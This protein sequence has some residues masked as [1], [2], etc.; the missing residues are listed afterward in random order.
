MLGCL[1]LVISGSHAGSGP[2]CGERE[3]QEIQSRVSGC[4]AS[5]TFQFEDARDAA[6][7][8][9]DVREDIRMANMDLELWE[10]FDSFDR[11]DAMENFIRV[12]RGRDQGMEQL[13]Q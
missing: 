4:L 12:N 10:T 5:A 8:V 9:E 1:L 7:E 3:E 11:Q 6:R 2:E 13:E